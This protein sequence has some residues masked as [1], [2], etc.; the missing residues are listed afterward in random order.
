MGVRGDSKATGL[1]WLALLAG[2]LWAVPAIAIDFTNRFD[3]YV[4]DDI[5]VSA[6]AS[7]AVAAKAAALDDALVMS[8]M[9]VLRRVAASGT[10]PEISPETAEQLLSSYENASE[11]VGTTGYSAT[12]KMVYSPMLVRGFLAR[13]GIAV[14]DRPAPTVL[15]IPIVIE[16][17]E[18]H[19]WDD[20]A[21]WA[22][23]LGALDME[24]RLTPVRL[25]GNTVE[26]KAARRD[27]LLEGDFLTLGQFRVRY[28]T[29]SAVIVRLDRASDGEGMLLSLSGEDAAGPINVTT[30]V[31]S[32]GLDAA[33]VRVGDILA[34][35]WKDVAMGS[36]TIGLALGSSLPVR[37]LLT[38]GPE[39]WEVLKNRLEASGAVNG[40]AV[41]SIGGSDANIVIWFT[42]RPADLPQRL[43][44]EGL[45][46]FEAGG[47]WLLQAY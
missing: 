19:W 22:G 21:D 14:V 3:P 41:E 5:A 35:R 9:R 36:G 34:E 25:P 39:D 8:G 16:D 37:A 47:T 24:E 43:A 33:A 32:G 30:E 46:L 12:Y 1:A 10:P 29:H 11:Q 15:L 27:R 23:A 28:H 2:L 26:D 20:A 44:R 40:L 6:V 17:G 7:D 45:D 38:G 31:P 18:E 13:R 42:G 4:V